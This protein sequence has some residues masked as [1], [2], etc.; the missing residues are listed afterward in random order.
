VF[1]DLGTWFAPGV[2]DPEARHKLALN[3]CNGCHSQQ[4]AGVFFLQIVPRFPGSQAGLSGFLTGT[5]V[6]DVATG[7]PRVLDDLARR[8]ADMEAIVCPGAAAKPADL[9]KGSDRVH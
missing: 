9:R 8:K 6:F 7:Q 3:T 5:T 2:S 1:N 4:E